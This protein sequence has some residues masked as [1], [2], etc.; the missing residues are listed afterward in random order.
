MDEVFLRREANMSYVQAMSA[1]E[2]EDHLRPNPIAHSTPG[3]KLLK[4][5]I[6]QAHRSRFNHQ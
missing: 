1:W 5:D 6:V 2:M 3:K 4:A